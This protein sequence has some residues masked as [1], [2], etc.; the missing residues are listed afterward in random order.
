MREQEPQHNNM[1]GEGQDK[2]VY[3]DPKHEERV[4]ARYKDDEL[5]KGYGER[6][7]DSP[8]RIKAQYYLTKILH[9]LFPKNIPE[10]HAAYS[11]PHMT[12]TDRIEHDA[13]L[14]EFAI[15]NEKIKKLDENKEPWPQELIDDQIKLSQRSRAKIIES[16]IEDKIA[17]EV[18][19]HL[20]PN[21][22]NFTVD[23]D[24]NI[25]YLETLTP[26]RVE[27][28]AT[29]LEFDESKLMSAINGLSENDQDKAHAYLKRLME[30]QK[31]E[32]E[33][34]SK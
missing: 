2:R 24:G 6:K 25:W 8:E 3:I 13:D 18:G 22:E 16:G 11:K 5:P 32:L 1:I 29:I 9:L 31:Q 33:N 12:K 19:I 10:M 23:K 15:L 34:L 21:E 26:W 27:D 28:N 7:I 30:L 14:M 20:D 4:V 17:E